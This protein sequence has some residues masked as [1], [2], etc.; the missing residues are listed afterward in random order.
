MTTRAT[1]VIPFQSR[2]R[3]FV[4]I[5]EHVKHEGRIVAGEPLELELR[6]EEI[7]IYHKAAEAAPR[8]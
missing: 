2:G 3:L 1:Y 8:V 6:G 5:P 7:V 4:E